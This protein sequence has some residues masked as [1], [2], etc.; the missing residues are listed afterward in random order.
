MAELCDPERGLFPRSRELD[1]R[2]SCPDGAWLCKH[3]AAVLYGVGAR[4]DE[5]PELLFTLRGVELAALVADASAIGSRP[6]SAPGAR[7]T[8]AE[9][10]ELFGIDLAG[11]ADPP[12]EAVEPG[13]RKQVARGRP[14]A[15]ARGRA[16]G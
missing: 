15:R 9:L 5:A 12:G 16:R 14:R 3:L 13:R 10:A 4:L 7:F 2:C 11:P 1:L 6:A 8:D